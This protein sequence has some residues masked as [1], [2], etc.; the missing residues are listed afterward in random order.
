MSNPSPP[1]DRAGWQA[2]IGEERL[3]F[4]LEDLR[5]LAGEGKLRPEHYVYH[6]IIQRWMYAREVAELR[7]AFVAREAKAIPP[8]AWVIQLNQK[9][10]PAEDLEMLRRWVRDGR[11]TRG[12]LVRNPVLERWMRAGD[13]LEL[14][15]EFEQIPDIPLQS[16][17]E[18]ERMSRQTV[19]LIIAAALVVLLA[20]FGIYRGTAGNNDSEPAS[21]PSAAI[22]N[23]ATPAAAPAAAKPA[24]KPAMTRWIFGEPEKKEEETATTTAVA[25]AAPTET[26]ATVAPPPTATT[27][28]AKPEKKPEP[29]P[30]RMDDAESL[31]DEEEVT[32]QGTDVIRAQVSGDTQVFID[33]SHHDS[34]YH[35]SACPRV[36][37][38]MTKVSLDLARQ[39]YEPCPVCKPPK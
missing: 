16:T 23:T 28:E 29:R 24:K 15:D 6:P 18:P 14:G 32:F 22:A 19:G 20:A 8:D 4:S 9:R 2:R 35:V 7:D 17:P 3:D 21:P 34:N 26:V 38:G 39:G 12:T 10:Y 11:V 27:E 25:T 13:V 33:R 31:Y 5:S 37:S 36:T 1:S 30:R